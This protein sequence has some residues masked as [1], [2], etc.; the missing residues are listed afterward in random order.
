MTGVTKLYLN[1]AKDLM[2]RLLN[3]KNYTAIKVKHLID[4]NDFQA[5]NGTDFLNI[6]MDDTLE[7]GTPVLSEL[8]KVL[9]KIEKNMDTD[10]DRQIFALISYF[11]ST[12]RSYFDEGD[13]VYSTLNMYHSGMFSFQLKK[14][15]LKNF[16]MLLQIA[17]MENGFRIVN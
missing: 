6:L 15:R 7:N 3:I 17:N 8:D 4:D 10:T 14:E 1:E 12:H 11:C 2:L 16:K 5:F 13:T 9:K